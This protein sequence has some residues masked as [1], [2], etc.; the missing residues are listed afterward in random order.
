MRGKQFAYPIWSC[1]SN[2]ICYEVWYL[3]YRETKLEVKFFNQTFI[4]RRVLALSSKVFPRPDILTA[5]FDFSG[6]PGKFSKNY[7]DYANVFGPPAP[8]H[9]I[10]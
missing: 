4:I 8:R 1:S 2:L 6:S 10:T 3:W 9:L 7:S 5:R